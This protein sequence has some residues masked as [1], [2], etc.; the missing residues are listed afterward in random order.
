MAE[1]KQ[2]PVAA[3]RAQVLGRSLPARIRLQEIARAIGDIG[4][5]ACADIGLDNPMISYH[6]RRFGGK[7]HTV[8]SSPTAAQ[9]V[10]EIVADDVHV[11]EG[12][13]LPFKKKAF[14]VVVVADT[15]E[16]IQDDEAF[17]EECHRVLKPDGRLVINVARVKTWS[18]IRL[19]RRMVGLTPE[20][21]GMVRAGYT[22]SQL[23]GILKH[24]FDVY[25]MRA[26]SRFFVELTTTVLHFLSGGKATA[27]AG[28]L[29]R[30]HRIMA[31]FYWLAFQLDL[32]LFLTKGYYLIAV[33][34]RRAWRPRRAPVLVDGRSISE[35]VLSRPDE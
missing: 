4:E 11:L 24:G 7:W 15:L 18:L 34:K 20:K 2:T 5:M 33:A 28:R 16:W 19:L 29:L 13:T 32:L 9:N 17:I 22:E 1:A 25:L 35:A 14:D 31:P 3:E 23:F 21:K 12:A 30:A 6:L 10:S 8:V 26:Y 27:E